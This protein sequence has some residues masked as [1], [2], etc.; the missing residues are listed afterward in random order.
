MYQ[1]TGIYTTALMLLVLL[2]N[3]VAKPNLSINL[4]AAPSIIQNQEFPNTYEFELDN[5]LKFIVRKDNRAPVVTTMI[6]Y[7]IGSVDEPRSLGGISH[8]LEHMMFKGTRLADG[9]LNLQPNEHSR[10]ISNF[11]GNDN[12]FTSRDYTAYF[13]TL[14]SEHLE[15]AFRLESDRMQNLNLHDDD[16]LSE[17]QV[18]AEERSLR[19]DSDPQAKFFEQFNAFIWNTSGYRNPVIGYANEI[20][21]YKLDDLRAWYTAYYAPNNATVVVVGDVDVAK[22]LE[23]AQQYFGGLARREVKPLALNFEIKQQGLKRMDFQIEAKTPLLVMSYKAPSINTLDDPK[24][25]DAL[26]M[27]AAILDGGRSSRLSKSLVREQKIAASVSANYD[28]SPRFGS[29]FSFYAIPSN[30]VDLTVIE[31]AILAEIDKLKKIPVSTD[32]LKRINAQLRAVMVYQQDSLMSQASMLGAAQT[33]GEGWVKREK[34]IQRLSQISADDILNVAQK[35]LI[36]T[37]LS[38][39]TLTPLKA[40]LK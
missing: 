24:D 36:D 26:L 6:W 35:Y 2:N 25:A 18:V 29:T 16:F 7:K 22:T 33:T 34:M 11:G 19:T 10:L 5:G 1:K 15:L 12:A 30:N 14:P 13:E 27:L 31:N 8:M 39:G 40:Q 4:N 3:A 21:A 9:S 32:E 28:S 23:L 17:R 20:Q 37:S 38:I